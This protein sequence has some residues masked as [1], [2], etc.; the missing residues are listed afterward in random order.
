[1]I[2]THRI[3]DHDYPHALREL[4][5]P[6]D[7]VCVRGSL[8]GGPALAIVG[9]RQAT[10]EA[11]SFTRRLAARFAERGVS[12]WSG[13]AIGIDAAAHRGALD[14]GGI[15]VAV[16]PTG[17]DHCY[18]TQHR[19]LYDE[20]VENGG[21]IVSPFEPSHQAMLHT[22]HQR[23]GVLAALTMATVVVQAPIESGARS[24]ASAARKLRRPLFI[25]PSAPWEKEG[26]GN[27]IELTLPGAVPFDEVLVCRLLGV[28][29]GGLVKR[30]REAE[31]R[32]LEAMGSGTGTGT[33]TGT[34][35]EE[36]VVEGLSPA[37]RS[38]FR[39]CSTTPRHTEDLCSKTGLSAALVQEALLTLTLHAV[40]VEGPCGWFRRLS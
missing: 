34:G 16:V 14:A 28:E 9:T 31:K 10:D 4:R 36:R 1:M 39:E 7:P 2:R 22:F 6:P 35:S 19:A 8:L 11:L 20:I 24:T 15:T 40:L 21:A 5:A 25:V 12:L 23:N 30:D 3:L 32:A 29:E 17:L 18:P 37:C 33:R 26:E 38:I 13:G 27:A